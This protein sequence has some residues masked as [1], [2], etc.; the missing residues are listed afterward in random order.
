M[1]VVRD[2][3][4]PVQQSANCVEKELVG[5]RQSRE[6]EAL[7][8]SQTRGREPLIQFDV[9]KVDPVGGAV[10]ADSGSEAIDASQKI[11][12]L[13]EIFRYERDVSTGAE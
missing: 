7:S 8:R 4:I 13:F 9:T 2:R 12:D 6:G 1:D 10:V 11:L 3:A 5:D